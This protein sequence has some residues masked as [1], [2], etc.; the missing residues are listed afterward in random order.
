MN[1][2]VSIVPLQAYSGSEVLRRKFGPLAS[3]DIGHTGNSLNIAQDEAVNNATKADSLTSDL[4][5]NIAQGN[6][7]G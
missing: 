6:M 1:S 3:H 2:S 4:K 7:G 5:S